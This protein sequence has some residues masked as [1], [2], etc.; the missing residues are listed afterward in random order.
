MTDIAAVAAPVKPPYKPQ[1]G[2]KRFSRSRV[3]NHVDMIGPVD[4]RSPGARRFRDL[5]RAFIV[6]LGGEDN[7]S[8]VVIGLARRLAAAT[9]MAEGLELKAV[10][11]EPVDVATYCNLASTT[12]RISQRLGLKRVPKT[13]V[14]DLKTYLQNIE[15]EE[16]DA[17]A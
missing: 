2:D 11:G 4:G 9:V 15:H 3:S 13:V 12:V 17:A 5:V 16:E 6:D 10:Q 14:P 8:E 1:R 7:C